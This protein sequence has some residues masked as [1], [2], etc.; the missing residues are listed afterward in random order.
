MW[1]TFGGAFGE[2]GALTEEAGFAA[3]G[4]EPRAIMVD[5]H[6][7]AKVHMHLTVT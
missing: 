7:H 2:D 4:T 3:F 6:P 5:G 1:V